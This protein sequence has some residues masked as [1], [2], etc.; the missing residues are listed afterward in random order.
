MKKTKT[1]SSHAATLIRGVRTLCAWNDDRC[2]ID[3]LQAWASYLGIDKNAFDK[4]VDELV[5][6]GRAA[7]DET[8][9]QVL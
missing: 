9:L 6:A 3:I 2:E 8:D 5:K 7:K 4:A 1:L